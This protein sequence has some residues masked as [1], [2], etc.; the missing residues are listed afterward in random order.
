MCLFGYCLVLCD[1]SKGELNNPECGK[2]EYCLPSSSGGGSVCIPD[3]SEKKGAPCSI[4]KPCKYGLSCAN[5]GK[6]YI[7]LTD[8]KPSGGGAGN[9]DCESNE[10]CS[11][12]TGTPKGGVCVP[13][14]G[15][16]RKLYE[17]CDA[18][19][20]CL[21]P[22]L[23]VGKPGAGTWCLQPCDPTAPTPNCPTGFLCSGY[24]PSSP[25]KGICLQ[26]CSKTGTKDICKYGQCLQEQTE[27]LCL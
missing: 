12:A 20:P 25:K 2:D 18:A 23:C 24:D 27:K 16:A 1:K 3:G 21:S 26:R 4:V 11:P 8:C 14:P 6:G 7:C 17:A 10:L 5:A 13:L 22:N 19:N 9:P 15:K